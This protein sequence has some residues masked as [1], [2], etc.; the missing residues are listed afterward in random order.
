MPVMPENIINEARVIVE[1]DFKNI[2]DDSDIAELE[3]RIEALIGLL[4]DNIDDKKRISYGITYVINI[5]SKMLYEK[6]V[7]PYDV[8]MLLYKKMQS[9]RVRCLGLGVLSHVG[10]EEP[11]AI[12]P[13]LAEAA[14]SDQWETKE[15]VQMFV[16]KIMKVHPEKARLF[17]IKMAKSEDANKRRLASESFR[18]VAENKWINDN[19]EFSLSVL[20]LLFKESDSYPRVSVGN[21]LSD[22]SRKHPELIFSVVEELMA[23]NDKNSKFIAHRACRNLVIKYPLRVMD[24]LGCD[25]YKYKNRNYKRSEIGISGNE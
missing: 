8:G 3:K 10:V 16:R 1:V 13:I 15:F 9:Y 18:P 6:C 24:I 21:N 22:L 19:P 5:L 12:L 20:R 4:H 7:S 11:D 14:S 2:S 17:L 23:L 25:E